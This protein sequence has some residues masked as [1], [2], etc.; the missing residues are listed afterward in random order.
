MNLRDIN[1]CQFFLDSHT[2]LT[3]S[4]SI[5]PSQNG[6]TNLQE[7]V[8]SRGCVTTASRPL[9]GAETEQTQD[10]GQCSLLLGSDVSPHLTL[11]KSQGTSVT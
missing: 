2:Q 8:Y 3:V 10:S 11:L 9:A 7:F 1:V 5:A 4:V 6:V